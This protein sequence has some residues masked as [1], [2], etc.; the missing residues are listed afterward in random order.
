MKSLELLPKSLL[1]PKKLIT[2]DHIFNTILYRISL[3]SSRAI[4][5]CASGRK[6]AKDTPDTPVEL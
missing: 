4:N 3:S 1:L 6:T 5:C 2:I